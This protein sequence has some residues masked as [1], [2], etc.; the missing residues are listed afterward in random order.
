MQTFSDNEIEFIEADK[1]EAPKYKE[2]PERKDQ[3]ELDIIKFHISNQSYSKFLNKNITNIQEACTHAVY[4]ARQW[5]KEDKAELRKAQNQRYQ[6]KKKETFVETNPVLIKAKMDW[7][8][9]IAKR[10]AAMEEWNLYVSRLQHEYL[11]IKLGV[12]NDKHIK[13]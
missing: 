9:A 8:E 7:Q 1:K 2:K 5:E 4:S 6:Q 10:K 3:F 13:A 12:K 11:R